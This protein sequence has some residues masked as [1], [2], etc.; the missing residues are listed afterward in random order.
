MS[1][2]I[3]VRIDHILANEFLE[4]TGARLEGDAG[5]DH[6]PISATLRLN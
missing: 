3:R 4:I 2:W 1:G 5:S 6:L